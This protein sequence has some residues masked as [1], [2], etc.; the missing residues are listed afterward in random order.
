MRKT[1]ITGNYN[2]HNEKSDLR[3]FWKRQKNPRL[4]AT[5]LCCLLTLIFVTCAICV[6]EIWLATSLRGK[7]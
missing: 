2:L 3:W 1:E 7:I 4:L 6:L 5:V